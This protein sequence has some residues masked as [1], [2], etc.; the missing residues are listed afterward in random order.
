[1]MKT[2]LFE[3]KA[4]RKIKDLIRMKNR[5]FQK[6]ISNFTKFLRIQFMAI[7]GVRTH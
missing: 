7:D 3:Q 2:R 5:E 4:V 1:M 6:M